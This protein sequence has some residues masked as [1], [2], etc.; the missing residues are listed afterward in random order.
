MEEHTK[1][2]EPLSEELLHQITGGCVACTQMQSTLAH[3][4][5]QAEI[6][7]RIANSN[8]QWE[9]NDVADHFQAEANYHNS[10][11]Q[12]AQIMLNNMRNLHGRRRAPGNS[13]SL[14]PA[15]KRPRI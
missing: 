4:T 7:Q 6:N 8:R 9:L 5:E 15:N 2:E 1:R 10:M 13:S 12:T 14:E 3:H 11:A